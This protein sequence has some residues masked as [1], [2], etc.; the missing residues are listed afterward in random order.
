MEWPACLEA[1]LHWN[2]GGDYHALP[3]ILAGALNKILSA[4]DDVYVA[5]MGIYF[6]LQTFLYMPSNGIVQGLRPIIS[7]NFGAWTL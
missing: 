1:L 5:V 2:S 7:C 3:S 6:K 4:Y